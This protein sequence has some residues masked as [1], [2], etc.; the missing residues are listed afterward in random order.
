MHARLLAVVSVSSSVVLVGVLS[1]SAT[2]PSGAAPAFSGVITYAGSVTP[3]DRGR[4]VE[5]SFTVPPGTM[6][7]DVDFDHP[8]SEGAPI[9]FDLGLRSPDGMRG[10]SE[11]HSRRIH[12]D[13]TSASYGYLPGPIPSGEWTALVGV[14]TVPPGATQYRLQV[15]LSRNLD[16]VR[17][18]LRT[19]E[20][21]YA[22][23]LHTHSGHSDG[24]RLD[25]TGKQV[26]IAVRDIATEAAR[27]SLDFV[28]V[29]DHNTSSH[30]IDVD[31]TQAADDRVLLLHAREVTT[32]QGHFNAVGERRASD[33]AL[34]A[35]RPM[36]RLMA[37]AASDGSFVVVNHPWLP[38]DDWCPGCA[39]TNL[40]R[41]TVEAAHALEIANGPL[42]GDDLPGWRLWVDL[43]NAG[44][45]MVAV[46]GSDA[47]TLAGDRRRLGEPATVVYAH[48]LSEDDLVR[49]LKSG[50]VYGRST[51]DGPEIDIAA[52][53]AAH[54][55]AMG[56]SLPP[57][58]ARVIAT[59]GRA[60]GQQCIWI[61]RGQVVRTER[62]PSNHAVLAV[63]VDLA[64]GDWVSVLLRR[65]RRVSAWSNPIY[66][67]ADK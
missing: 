27:R 57:G 16:P 3:H 14:A 26:P 67:D 24:H 36:R 21:W 41:S 11:D 48:A 58:P 61:K 22:G 30:W 49:G 12:I 42:D 33:V 37:D 6:T 60:A 46:G 32:Y 51:R 29:T 8:E 13:G 56:Q 28:A 52:T 40:D 53:S 35:A 39:W 9:Q 59:I 64:A 4:L 17:R 43:L 31:R 2:A 25:A 62:I 47:H 18:V 55:A 7:L 63:D 66:V 38:D 54:S 50:R 5:Y 20:G 1:T 65:E 19:G 45:R 15:R 34:T 10:W 23:D 44:Q